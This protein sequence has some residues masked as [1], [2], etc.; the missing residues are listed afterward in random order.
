MDILAV[1][2]SS[3]SSD[4]TCGLLL[5][6]ANRHGLIAGATGTGKTVTLQVLAEQFSR[7][8]VPVF[9]ADIKGDLSGLAV[10]GGGNP[11]VAARLA[12]LGLVNFEYYGNPTVFWDIA[13]KKGHPVRATVSDMGP[14]L[15]ARMLCLNP[16]QTGI[17]TILFRIADDHGLLLLDLKDLHAMLTYVSENA[18]SLSA[19]YGHI[20]T[21]STGAI[22]RSLLQLAQEGGDL[23]FGEP[24][25][26][27]ADLMKTDQN[28]RG[29]INILSAESLYR[30][31]RIYATLLLW[32]LS[33][34]FEHLPETGD[35]ERPKLIFFFDEAHLLFSNAPRVLLEKIEQVVRLIRSKGV[36]VYF[37]SQNPM[38]IPETVLDAS[39]GQNAIEQCSQFTQATDVN[40][41]A[42]TKLDGTAKGGVVIGISDQFK[43]PVKYIGIGEKIGDLQLFN[44]KEFVDSLFKGSPHS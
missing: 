3:T 8:G 35:T 14:L 9:M 25:L 4:R 18:R 10:P 22:Q 38:D 7:A 5:Q 39:T 24:M 33:E 2:R 44:K 16:V 21:A 23:L 37:V 6:M 31:P 41:L 27:I 34:L 20:S 15:L 12:E 13:G 43:I 26:A 30:T 29:M 11:K 28:G 40:A 1:A 32:L 19:K 17:L 42:L 36:G